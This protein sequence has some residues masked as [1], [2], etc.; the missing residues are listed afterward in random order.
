MIWIYWNYFF[1]VQL[2]I[3]ISI[4]NETSKNPKLIPKLDM[5]LLK[6]TKALK[7]WA[8]HWNII[9]VLSTDKIPDPQ[10]YENNI[11][12]IRKQYL[13]IDIYWKRSKN[14]KLIPKLDMTLL[15]KNTNPKLIPKLDI[16]LFN[17]SKNPKL[18]PKIHMSQIHLYIFFKLKIV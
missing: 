8:M 13:H 15:G 7:H 2:C 12:I 9:P 4:F 16:T 1:G 11:K 17:I 3:K 6:N 10:K 14:P 5:N 18:I